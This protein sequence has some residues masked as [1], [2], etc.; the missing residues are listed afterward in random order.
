[1]RAT[2]AVA[3]YMNTAGVFYLKRR[4]AG[5]LVYNIKV[6]RANDSKTYGGLFTVITTCRE[7]SIKIGV[8]LTH[9]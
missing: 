6:S 8:I 3:Y 2:T 4:C 5:R 9:M 1:M 7:R